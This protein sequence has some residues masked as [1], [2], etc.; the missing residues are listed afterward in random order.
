MTKI[1]VCSRQ[2]LNT[3]ITT[4]NIKLENVNSFPYLRNKITRD[5]KSTTDMNFRIA[6]AKLV[7]FKKKKLFITNTINIIKTMVWCV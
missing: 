4:N 5:G 6:Q 7:F 1:L 2:K 3:N